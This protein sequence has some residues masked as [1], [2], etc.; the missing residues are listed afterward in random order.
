MVTAPNGKPLQPGLSG[1]PVFAVISKIG[2][3]NIFAADSAAQ[4]WRH[5]FPG[6]FPRP[7]WPR[8]FSNCQGLTSLGNPGKRPAQ[9]RREGESL[10]DSNARSSLI[11]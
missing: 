7:S 1:S 4:E 11:C 9:S 2:L 10:D 5:A 3:T 8:S 6:G